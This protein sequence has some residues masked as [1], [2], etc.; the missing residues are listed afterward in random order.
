MGMTIL[1]E[2]DHGEEGKVAQVKS[3]PMKPG[4]PETPSHPVQSIGLDGEGEAGGRVKV[5]V[6]D[7]VAHG[8]LLPFPNGRYL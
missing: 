7:A 1:S 8:R 3:A 6:L 4:I 5:K 2:S